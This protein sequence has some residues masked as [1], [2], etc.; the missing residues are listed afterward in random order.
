MKYT[1]CIICSLLC[2]GAIAIGQAAY[3]TDYALEDLRSNELNSN[4]IAIYEQQAIFKLQD[5]LDYVRLI[6]SGQFNLALRNTALESIL[7]N[8]DHNA[9]VF[10]DWIN[11]STSKNK[12][13]KKA[14][15][16]CFPQKML[17]KLFQQPYYSIQV[18]YQQIK[19]SK[20]LQKLS[21]GSYQGQLSYQQQ[22]TTKTSKTAKTIKNT[23]SI[24]FIDFL[25]KRVSKKFGRTTEKIWEIKFINI[26]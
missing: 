3:H 13:K 16:N 22:L 2:W 14:N 6:G 8:F 17:R 5:V 25:L 26:H 19:I 9:T 1:I 12:Q 18:N 7:V 10:C 15:T 23:P 21:N 11:S 24:I 20:P 4:N